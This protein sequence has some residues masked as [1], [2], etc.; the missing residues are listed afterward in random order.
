MNTTLTKDGFDEFIIQY[1]RESLKDKRQ[2]QLVE[3]Y[4]DDK[5]G[6]FLK[7]LNSRGIEGQLNSLKSFDDLNIRTDVKIHIPKLSNNN[8]IIIQT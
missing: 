3:S 8:I 6:Y 5:W 4:D 7:L 1:I 2:Y